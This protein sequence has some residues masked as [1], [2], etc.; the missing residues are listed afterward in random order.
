MKTL[1]ICGD[2]FCST[3]P[4]YP[5]SWVETFQMQHPDL[6]VI[7]LAIPGASNFQ[8]YLQVKEALA[9]NCNYLIYHATSSIRH[10]FLAHPLVSPQQGY[11]N[12]WDRTCPDELR[13]MVCTSWLTPENSLIL[14]ASQIKL[15]KTFFKKF[16]NLDSEVEKNYLFI[17]STLNLINDSGV[18][19]W[20][21]S[22]GGFEHKNFKNAKS[23]LFDF[24][25][26][27]VDY[28]L[29]DYYDAQSTRPFYHISDVSVIE[30]ACKHY[31]N[32]LNLST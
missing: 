16:I 29:W 3:D 12:Y 32:M 22:R 14:D 30:T 23:W 7:S 19:N 15:I 4:E 2:S 1:Y 28:N 26:R 25:D 10:E 24:A 20:L 18:K 5:G 6:C 17:I 27:E 11:K 21:W 13:Q 9:Q 31:S 8:I